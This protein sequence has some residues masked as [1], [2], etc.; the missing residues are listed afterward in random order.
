MILILLKNLPPR[1]KKKKEEKLQTYESN[2]FIGQ[3]YFG[4]NGSQNFLIFQAILKNFH[5]V[6]WYYRYNGKMGI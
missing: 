4:N 6:S 2:L 3:S 5:N 1:M